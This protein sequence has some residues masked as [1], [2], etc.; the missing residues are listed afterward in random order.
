M[1]PL[2]SWERMTFLKVISGWE[3]LATSLPMSLFCHAGY[4]LLTSFHPL[5]NVPRMGTVATKAPRGFRMWGTWAAAFGALL[6][7]LYLEEYS[8]LAPA[9]TPRHP[10]SFQHFLQMLAMPL[11]TMSHSEHSHSASHATVLLREVGSLPQDVHKKWNPYKV[12]K[13]V[14]V[15]CIMRNHVLLSLQQISTMCW[16]LTS[17]RHS[18]PVACRCIYHI[19]VNVSQHVCRQ[20]HTQCQKV[21][22]AMLGLQIQ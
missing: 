15:H 20:H 8:T 5:L 11:R 2:H 22:R 3:D 21:I 9:H 16:L 1:C 7:I 10:C 4:G 13:D 18:Q 12:P 17:D 19:S 6:A 14:R